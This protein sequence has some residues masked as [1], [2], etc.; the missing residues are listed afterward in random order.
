MQGRICVSILAC[1]RSSSGLNRR[2]SSPLRFV[3]LALAVRSGSATRQLKQTQKQRPGIGCPAGN[4]LNRE[5]WLSARPGRLRLRPCLRLAGLQ[6]L[7]LCRVPLRQLLRLLLMLLFQFLCVGLLLMFRF[8]L[9]L[10]VLPLLSLFGDQLVLLLFIL[11][12]CLRISR[13]D[14]SGAGNRRKIFWMD[15][16]AGVSRRITCLPYA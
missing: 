16:G 14:R 6:C 4:G 3:S 9:Q 10:K 12:V 13:V 11:L 15:C 7:L 1:R 8:L 5:S 2:R